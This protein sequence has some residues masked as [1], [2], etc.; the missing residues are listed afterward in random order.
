MLRDVSGRGLHGHRAHGGRRQ[1]CAVAHDRVVARRTGQ[2]ICSDPARRAALFVHSHGR[3]GIA[4]LGEIRIGRAVGCTFGVYSRGYKRGGTIGGTLFLSPIRRLRELRSVAERPHLGRLAGGDLDTV[5]I[6]HH[7]RAQGWSVFGADRGAYRDVGSAL[8]YR[9]AVG[10]S[11]RAGDR[12]RR[13]AFL[14][15]RGGRADQ[16]SRVRVA[17]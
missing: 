4:L 7:R 16:R 13:A 10:T 8:A 2:R 14:R 11:G 1:L 15:E 6:R 17:M 3:E 9:R 5:A 12:G